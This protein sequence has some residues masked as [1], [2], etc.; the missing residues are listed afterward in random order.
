L[1]DSL[2]IIHPSAELGGAESQILR[3]LEHKYRDWR[4][5]LVF[6]TRGGALEHV[7]KQLDVE[8]IFCNK[9]HWLTWPSVMI[10][11]LRLIL[12]RN[13]TVIYT[14]LPVP[15]LIGLLLGRLCFVSGVFWGVR[16][17]DFQPEF[18]SFRDR[19][20]DRLMSW[21]SRFT[22]GIIANSQLGA[23]H[24]KTRGLTGAPIHVIPNGI[25]VEKRISTRAKYLISGEAK[26]KIGVPN[27]HIVVGI[28]A[29]IVPWKGHS[30]LLHSVSSLKEQFPAI[31]LVIVGG[32]EEIFEKELKRL[33][34]SL[35][36]KDCVVWTGSQTNPT[37]I[38]RAF[39]IFVL[40]SLAGEGMSNSVAEAMALGIPVLGSD[41]GG[42]RELI[43][44]ERCIFEPGNVNQLT[45][46]LCRL[47]R[48]RELRESTGDRAHSR[49]LNNFSVEQMV[50]KTWDV[51]RSK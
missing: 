26:T 31:S 22:T 4:I 28:V 1:T 6:L 23:D 14:L 41:V 17:S 44:D 19:V 15:N 50:I 32:G 30:V 25:L 49:I 36:L 9:H 24:A 27:S 33:S 38:M 35:N 3:L 18:C 48:S 40:P 29:R 13:P 45:E 46:L 39:D 16:T 47:C 10:R 7:F 42:M 21:C 43:S 11:L 2:L 20:V 37:E 12:S 51:L 34:G 8:V 5:T